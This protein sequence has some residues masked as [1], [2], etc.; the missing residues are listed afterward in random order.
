MNFN[1]LIFNELIY[2]TLKVK[3]LEYIKHVYNYGCKLYIFMN[4]VVVIVKMLEYVYNYG[5]KLYTFINVVIVKMLYRYKSYKSRNIQLEDDYQWDKWKYSNAASN[6]YLDYLVYYHENGCPW[7]KNACRYAALN[8]HLNC[9]KYAHENG[10]PWDEYTCYYATE[11]GHL[12]CLK[13]AYENKCTWIGER[14]CSIAAKNGQLKCLMYAHDN[15]SYWNE[16]TCSSASENGHLNCLKFAHENGCEW[17][18]YTCI[19]AAENGH[20]DCLK[21]AHQNGCEWNTWTC[22][23]AVKNGHLE[24]LKYAHHN[25]CPGDKDLCFGFANTK[26]HNKIMLYIN[27]ILS[28]N[29]YDN[30]LLLKLKSLVNETIKKEYKLARYNFEENRYIKSLPIYTNFKN[31]YNKSQTKKILIVYHGT[32]ENNIDN[33]FRCGLDSNKRGTAHGQIF[34]IGEYFGKYLD[35]SIPY[36]KGCNYVMI[37]AILMKYDG[38]VTDNDRMVVINKSEYQLP[39]GKI[40]YKN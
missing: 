39:I 28:F 1:I 37:F 13:Y 16:Y 19:K 2:F 24:C 30:I 15:G 20:L 11:N 38:I 12:D 21:Y 35:I 10:C 26:N 5:C 36:C 3:M 4:I 8:G 6:G 9:L 22:I 18:V 34:G 33:I 29:N 31:A 7:D 27:N 32:S 25:G 23:N 17:N 40:K 14:I